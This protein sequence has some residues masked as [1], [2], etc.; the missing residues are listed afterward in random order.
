[1]KNIIIIIIIIGD[2]QPALSSAT[3]A[4]K[5]PPPPLPSKTRLF[6]LLASH[7]KTKHKTQERMQT[8]QLPRVTALRVL[9]IGASAPV[10]LA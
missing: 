4:I 9:A 2:V 1:M 8:M 5:T 10:T 7:D 3:T 6:R